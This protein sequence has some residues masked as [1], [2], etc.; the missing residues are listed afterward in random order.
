MVRLDFWLFGYRK[1]TLE[2]ESATAD[3][4]AKM[5]RLGIVCAVGETGEILV[6]ERD[7]SR[8]SDIISGQNCAFVSESEGLPA[9]FRAALR[10]PVS[11]VAAA[12]SLALIIGAPSLV[13]DVRLV[14]GES[15]TEETLEGYLEPLGLSVGSLWSRVDTAK[16]ETALLAAHP[17]LA[18][19]N[20][21]RRGSVAYVEIRETE[22]VPPPTVNEGYANVVAAEDCIISEISVASGHA[23]VSV[24]EVVRRGDVLISGVLP[25]E[26]GGG[27]CYASGS[28]K[29]VVDGETSV[30]VSRTVTEKEYGDGS[31]TA[32][33]V[34]IFNFSI[35]IFKIYRNSDSECVII[36]NNEKIRLPN[37]RELPITLMR[38]YE[39]PV[40]ETERCLSDG[41]L[42]RLAGERMLETLRFRVGEGELCRAS[43]SGGFTE[44]GYSMKTKFAVIEEVGV[45]V[46]FKVDGKP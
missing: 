26:S 2:G 36:G 39:V 27:F 30:D 15:I 8:I 20:I 6:R 16:T 34:K 18:W 24:G 46:P 40:T 31:A 9:R 3:F 1:I 17:E 19:V 10:S 43:S 44:D 5:L 28:V 41:E 32:L 7:Y 33:S 13:W 35:N 14:G 37:G 11:L 12:L 29:G 38:E 22:D 45:T 21:N 23:L 42:T 4:A 25:P